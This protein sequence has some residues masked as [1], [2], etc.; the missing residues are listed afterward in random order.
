MRLYDPWRKRNAH[1]DLLTTIRVPIVPEI[2]ADGLVGK[3]AARLDQVNSDR[4]Q[5]TLY[6]L[7]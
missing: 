2:F 1:Y 7:W 6:R 4:L 3:P 5:R